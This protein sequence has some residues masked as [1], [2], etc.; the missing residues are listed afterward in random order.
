MINFQTA[1]K[2][3]KSFYLS[4]IAEQLN[5]KIN[6]LL[7]KIEQT[8]SDVAGKEIVK[9]CT[10]GVNGGVGAGSETGT[11]PTSGENSYEQFRLTLKN[12]FGKLEISD[13]ALRASQTDGGAFV[14]LLN[15]EM[16]GLLKASKMNF[17]RMLYG[18]GSGK[19]AGV[20]VSA[21]D[22]AAGVMSLDDVSNIYEGMIVDFCFPSGARVGGCYDREIVKVDRVNKKITV[23]SGWQNTSYGLSD[24]YMEDRSF[25]V[26]SNSV[27]LG[28]VWHINKKMD[29]NV[30]YFHT[31]YDHKK[32]S[33]QLN[34]GAANAP[35][36][37]ADYTRNNNVFGVGLDIH[38]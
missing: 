30:A 10:Y 1:E 17:G 35:T 22:E 16:D 34:T 33:E 5:T 28:G 11:L 15:A 20:S 9:L 27:A 8:S 2:A 32:T 21:E 23:S 36:Y 12:F 31:F 14:N 4:V 38:F 7:S 6:P 25:V 24:E 13:K 3:L 37:K 29:L 19:L 26:S 18:D